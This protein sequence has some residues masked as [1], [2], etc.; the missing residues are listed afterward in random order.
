M[1]RLCSI[2]ASP[3]LADVN[4][5]LVREGISF[6]VAASRFKLGRA[7]LARH[8]RGCLHLIRGAGKSAPPVARA[9]RPKTCRIAD[10]ADDDVL[11]PPALLASCAIDTRRRERHRER[12][13]A[14]RQSRPRTS[15]NQR[16][17]REC[18]TSHARRR[19]AFDGRLDIDHNRRATPIACAKRRRTLDRRTARTSSR[20][21]FDQVEVDGCRAHLAPHSNLSTDRAGAPVI[22]AGVSSPVSSGAGIGFE[23]RIVRGRAMIERSRAIRLF[24]RRQNPASKNSASRQT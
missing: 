15:C 6:S 4:A 21:R 11:D 24:G 18:R 13:K 10:D 19:F 7:A 14:K 17:S 3:Q 2:C 1:P 22:E 5:A 16:V 8:A 12:R 9:K 23:P 20:R